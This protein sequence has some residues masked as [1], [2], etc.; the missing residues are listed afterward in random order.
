MIKVDEVN[1]GVFQVVFTDEEL[2]MLSLAS[3]RILDSRD[4]V[5]QGWLAFVV[6]VW[7]KVEY[8]ERSQDGLEGQN[9]GMGRG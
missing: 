1:D 4:C 6:S 9:G 3:A 2:Q 8:L 5:L 7:N